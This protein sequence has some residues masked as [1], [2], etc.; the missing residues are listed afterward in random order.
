MPNNLL[1]RT[2]CGL[3]WTVAAGVLVGSPVVAQAQAE[4]AVR[5]FHLGL[6]LPAGRLGATMR[7]TVDNTA[8]NTQVP[9]P[10]R[11]RV[12]RDEISGNGFAYGVGAVGGYRLPLSGGRWFLEGEVGIEWHGGATEVSLRE[13]AFRPSAGSLGKAGP[14]DGAW[15]RRPVTARP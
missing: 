6:T 8:P 15:R 12:F 2:T 5:G 11:G 14:T 10:R 9:E 3:C 1:R 13:S 4:K 7:K